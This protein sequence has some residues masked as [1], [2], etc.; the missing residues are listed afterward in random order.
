MLRNRKYVQHRSSASVR[1]ITLH[2]A[3]IPL[4]ATLQSATYRNGETIN[5]DVTV[6]SDYIRKYEPWQ[7]TMHY[8]LRPPRRRHCYIFSISYLLLTTAVW[9]VESHFIRLLD[10]PV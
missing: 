8:H 10:I 9:F 7:L 6:Y 1:Q 3:T 2:R 4:P 5:T